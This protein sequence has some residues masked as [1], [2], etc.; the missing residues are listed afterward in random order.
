MHKN[1]G[2]LAQIRGHKRRAKV[3]AMRKRRNINSVKKE[4]GSVYMNR[5]LYDEE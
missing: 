4:V 3:L 1:K 2:K 5:F